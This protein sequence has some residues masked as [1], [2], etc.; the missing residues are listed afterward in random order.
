MAILSGSCFAHDLAPFDRLL[1][2]CRHAAMTG[3]LQV[4]DR[5]GGLM[6]H[7]CIKCQQQRWTLLYQPNARMATTM[8]PTLVAFGTFEPTLHIHVVFRKS[9]RLAPHKHP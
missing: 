8:H 5:T 1:L 3:R 4:L 9:G 6:M 7:V 2:A